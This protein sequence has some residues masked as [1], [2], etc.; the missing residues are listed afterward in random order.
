MRRRET[1]IAAVLERRSMMAL[2]L[3]ERLGRRLSRCKHERCSVRGGRAVIGEGSR[4]RQT[5]HRSGDGRAGQHKGESEDEAE[6]PH[7][8]CLRGRQAAV[9]SV[10]LITKGCFRISAPKAENGFMTG[11][12]C[13]AGTTATTHCG[14][15]PSDFRECG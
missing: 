9:W 2:V 14:K 1:A 8:N 6:G 5:V 4:G 15:K 12:N 7:R 3:L 13:F 10:S 11:E